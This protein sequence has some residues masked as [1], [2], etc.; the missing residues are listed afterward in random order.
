MQSMYKRIVKNLMSLIHWETKTIIFACFIINQ[1]Y[2]S[3]KA[4]QTLNVDLE[5]WI[6][7]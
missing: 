7:Q 6:F 5:I 1:R 3:T 2:S 4:I